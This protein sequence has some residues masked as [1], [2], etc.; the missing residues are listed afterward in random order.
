MDKSVE[1]SLA[2]NNW[3]IRKHFKEMTHT[4]LASFN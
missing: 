2:I 3:I 4:F 1:E